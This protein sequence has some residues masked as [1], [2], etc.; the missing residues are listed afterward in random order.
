VPESLMSGNLEESGGSRKFS[1]LLISGFLAPATSIYL[2]FF[3]IPV[4]CT[5]YISLFDWS[6]FGEAMKFVGVRN[7][8]RLWAD[9]IFWLSLRNT[10]AILVVGGAFVFGL[11]L[12]FTALIDSGI[13]GKK[14]FRFLFFLPNI[15]AVVAVSAMWSYI[16]NPKGGLLNGA[17]KALGFTNLSAFLWTSPEHIFWAMLVAIV[18]VNTGFFLILLLAGA[19]K[20]PRD[21]YEAAELDGA[22]TLKKFVFITVPMIWDVMVIS[23]VIWII[24]AMKMFEFPYA[25]GLIQ[26]PQQLYTLGVYLFIM[27]F[28]HREPIYQL[29]Y[30]A[31]IG[32][33]LL[34][35]TFSLIFL[36]RRLLRHA[37]LEF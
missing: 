6:G 17:L 31:A 37:T 16:Y 7:F 25:F 35:L 12:L 15:L 9:P 36:A 23:F 27:G 11:A 13:W 26:I 19:D 1:R 28:G 3:L 10:F 34:A 2:L 18:W 33:V 29:G 21:I 20:I 5:L 22:G 30:A 32:V 24:M 4:F 14:L 8:V